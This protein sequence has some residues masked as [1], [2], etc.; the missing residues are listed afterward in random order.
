VLQQLVLDI[1]F[2]NTLTVSGALLGG[3]TTTNDLVLKVASVGG[4]GQVTSVTYVSGNCFT[5]LS[6]I[7][8]NWRTL[9]YTAN[10][11]VGS[12]WTRYPVL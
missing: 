3:S 12:R 9:T 8:S 11:G 7:I 4:G 5:T 2:G 10:E 6:T 1:P